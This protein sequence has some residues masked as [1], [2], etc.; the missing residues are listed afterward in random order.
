MTANILKM[1]RTTHKDQSVL[2]SQTNGIPLQ[3]HNNNS[4]NAVLK[5]GP[6][7]QR[8]ES[9]ENGNYDINC[10]TISK[11]SNAATEKRREDYRSHGSS[12]IG[13]GSAETYYDESLLGS[14][15]ESGYSGA[16]RRSSTYSDNKIQEV[17]TEEG[18]ETAKTQENHKETI[19]RQCM[20]RSSEDMCNSFETHR[21]KIFKSDIE[22]IR[23]KLNESIQIMLSMDVITSECLSRYRIAAQQLHALGSNEYKNVTQ[24]LIEMETSEERNESVDVYDCNKSKKVSRLVSADSADVSVSPPEIKKEEN[25]PSASSSKSFEL[26]EEE[27]AEIQQ[28]HKPPEFDLLSENTYAS[29]VESPLS[30]SIQREE[31]I[32]LPSDCLDCLDTPTTGRHGLATLDIPKPCI[33][34]EALQ[35][36]SQCQ[37]QSCCQPQCRK[38]HEILTYLKKCSKSKQPCL[39]CR[40]VVDCL[41]HHSNLCEELK[42]SVPFCAFFRQHSSLSFEHCCAKLYT[43][44]EKKVL[45]MT[46]LEFG[47]LRKNQEYDWMADDFKEFWTR[48][49]T[50]KLYLVN[51]FLQ[52]YSGYG[53][54]NTV[55]MCIANS[56]GAPKHAYAIKNCSI[57]QEN[58]QEILDIMSKITDK[59]FPQIAKHLWCRVVGNSAYICT[60]LVKGG[61]LKRL[62]NS[63]SQQDLETLEQNRLSFLDQACMVAVHLRKLK[64]ILLDW[65]SDHISLDDTRQQLVFHD[66]SSAVVLD[67]T[68]RYTAQNKK[69]LKPHLTPIEVCRKQQRTSQSDVWGISTLLYEMSYKKTVFYHMSHEHPEVIR[70]KI[71]CGYKPDLTWC[72]NLQLMSFLTKCWTEDPNSR[73]FMHDARRHCIF[74]LGKDMNMKMK[75]C[76]YSAL[77]PKPVHAQ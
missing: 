51:E 21:E 26:P 1:S 27:F 2:H 57:A 33:Q 49:D 61:S 32:E 17:I 8:Q 7:L 73:L 6:L 71:G 37:D 25:H 59:R 39:D 30:P 24:D 67:A 77:R 58:R 28:S 38:V 56:V 9:L 42:C 36:S 14:S 19:L 46:L 4:T 47:W 15:M 29:N 64:I 20:K 63:T 18:R 65:S 12:G 70:N 3:Q 10:G 60:R 50:S 23:Q 31:S 13:S 34:R 40:D 52:D 74:F 76:N 48:K 54:F 43:L 35:L 5:N 68:K 44:F 75:P 22:Q 72:H 41:Y 66:F 69:Q 11:E 55:Q 53:M 62:I 16:R 45:I